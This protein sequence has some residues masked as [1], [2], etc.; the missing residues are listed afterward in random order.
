MKKLAT[1]RA[2]KKIT[3]SIVPV[4]SREGGVLVIGKVPLQCPVESDLRPVSCLK[5]RRQRSIKTIC[6]NLREI[7]L[8]V[9]KEGAWQ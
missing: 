2:T 7:G 3:T 6:D 5:Y 9:K 8:L 4:R 1:M